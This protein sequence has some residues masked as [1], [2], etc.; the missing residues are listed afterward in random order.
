MSR[1]VN[2]VERKAFSIFHIVHLNG[3]ALDGDAALALQ[4]HVVE[5]LGL[6]VLARHGIG[7]LEQ[8][9]G[10][11]ALAVVDV[12]HNAEVAYCLHFIYRDL[13]IFSFSGLQR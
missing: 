13:L 12:R 5:H 6:H 9:V 1:S 10:E 11:C 3:M 4:V 7:V 8:S 2:Q